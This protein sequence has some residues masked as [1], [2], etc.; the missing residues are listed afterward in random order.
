MRLKS[1]LSLADPGLSA[2]P[3]SPPV[4]RAFQDVI[5]SP[6]SLSSLLWHSAQRLWSKGSTSGSLPDAA[7]A[8]VAAKSAT[9]DRTRSSRRGFDPCRSI[10]R[11]ALGVAI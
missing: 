1:R 4:T 3:E 9:H 2:G 11:S 7:P 8:A 5:C 6:F 10:R